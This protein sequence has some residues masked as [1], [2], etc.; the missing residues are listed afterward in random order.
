MTPATMVLPCMTAIDTHQ[1]G[2]PNTK[3]LVPS[4]G[5]ITHQRG[6]HPFIDCIEDRAQRE[7]RF[8]AAAASSTFVYP[9]EIE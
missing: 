1:A 6:F 5:S 8:P 3:G 9:L 2:M 7:L 4:I